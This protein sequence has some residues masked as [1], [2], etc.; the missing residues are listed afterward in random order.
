MKI[1]N[2]QDTRSY[3]ETS[4]G[5]WAVVPGSGD[6][7]TCP[8]CGQPHVIHATVLLDNGRTE[9]LGREC[10]RGASVSLAKA[11][12]TAFNAQAAE[13]KLRRAIV[14]LGR[15]AEDWERGKAAVEGL[16]PPPLEVL[17]YAESATPLSV[18]DVPRITWGPL[19]SRLGPADGGAWYVGMRCG[20]VLGLAELAHFDVRHHGAGMAKKWRE[21][22]L[23]ERTGFQ[24]VMDGNAL[25]P[26]LRDAKKKLAKLVAKRER[27]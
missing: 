15:A 25:V 4:P 27:G 20:D 18:R 22:R 12:D 17:G 24:S 11:V 1:L 8:R 7:R 23:L 21:A 19:P 9:V 10:A 16:S 2:V 5:V 14:S 13:D 3:E 26:A 6:W